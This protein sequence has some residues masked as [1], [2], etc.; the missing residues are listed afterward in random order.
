MY[1]LFLNHFL[2]SSL[3]F[4]Y[5]FIANIFN[6]WVQIFFGIIF[7]GC[8]DCDSS[9]HMLYL[10]FLLYNIK[11]LEDIGLEHLDKQDRLSLLEIFEDRYGKRSSIITSQLPVQNWHEIIGDQTIADAI[12]DR[13]IH[14]SHRIELKGGSVRKKYSK[15]LTKTDHLK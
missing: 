10:F 6:W 8:F 4:K 2:I 15:I 12:C 13:V 3:V 9:N 11:F 5:S 7:Y 1:L 14:S